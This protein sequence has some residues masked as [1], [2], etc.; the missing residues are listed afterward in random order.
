MSKHIPTY[1]A[2]TVYDIDFN[3]LYEQ[4][5]RVILFDLDNT[6]AS[7]Q[8]TVPTAKQLELNAKLRNIGYK[9]YIVSNNRERRTKLYTKTFKVDKYLVLARKPFKRRI[10]RFIEREGIKK[11]EIIMIGDQLLTDIACANRLNVD[12]VLVHSISR[13]TE[14]WYTKINRLREKYILNAI[15]KEDKDLA[16]NIRKIIGNKGDHYE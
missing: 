12:C 11:E 5:K 1:L 14:K 10:N 4:G 7:Y 2:M 3:S 9:I 6:L 15:G 8:D 13:K 16:N